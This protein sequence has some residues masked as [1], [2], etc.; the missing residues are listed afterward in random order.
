MA[1]TPQPEPHGHHG[2]GNPEPNARVYRQPR[3]LV[4]IVVVGFGPFGNDLWCLIEN[5]G[6]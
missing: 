6:G 3:Q 1:P 2:R 4:R 5:V